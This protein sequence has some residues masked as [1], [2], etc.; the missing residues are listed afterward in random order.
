MLTDFE[1]K[2]AT[3]QERDKQ[4][5]AKS[6]KLGESIKTDKHALS[7][8]EAELRNSTVAADKYRAELRTLERNLEKHEA[9]L[10]QITD[11]L[12]GKTDHLQV[13]V[14]QHQRDLQPWQAQ[15]DDKRAALD[16]AASE[17]S[18]LEAKAESAQRSLEEAQKALTR[19]RADAEGRSAEI[20][21]LSDER[22]QADRVVAAAQAKVQ[23]AMAQDATLRA[24]SMAARAKHDEARANQSARTSKGKVLTEL[25]R[26][27]DQGRLDGF[28]GRL[29]NLG[30]ID[31]QYDVAVSTACPALDNLLCNRVETGQACLDH[32]RR[33]KA[34]RATIICLDQ[35]KV[36][37]AD[38]APRQYPEGVPRLYDL[39]TPKEPQY[40][41]AFYQVMKDTLVASDLAQANRIAFGGATRYRV[42]TLD[43]QLIDTSGTMSG[44][45]TRVARGMMSSKIQ[46]DVDSSP[47]AVARLERARID[48][49]EA[50][51]GALQER[52]AAE[53]EL[54]ALRRR[55]PELENQLERA[56]LGA[57]QDGKRVAD[58]ERRVAEL[59]AQSKPDSDDVR[60]IAELGRT[61]DKLKIELA[62]LMESAGEIEQAIKALKK[63][64]L[65]L[66]GLPVRWRTLLAAC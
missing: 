36:N 3:L 24:K 5:S 42:V 38:L 65:D 4:A 12:K 15:I 30:R 56:Q 31:D 11:S 9:E 51:Q 25:T 19:V 34:G 43:G 60:Q 22:A 8:A 50:L 20:A 55:I 64:I 39:V 32:L 46:S 2:E 27:R 62:T 54:K 52:E 26:L 41:A 14:E 66:G 23:A 57:R 48:A 59:R 6:K 33:T 58:A 45:G 17:R 53:A 28:I 63:Q 40:A 35:L 21:A 10:E 37:S 44:G 1:A 47:E 18:L 49:D 61:I 7:T 16:V 29:G 13:Q